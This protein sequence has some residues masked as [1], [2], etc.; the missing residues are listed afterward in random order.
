MPQLF[1]PKAGQESR[2]EFDNT[3][4][5]L[6]RLHVPKSVGSTDATHVDSPAYPDDM[7]KTHE[8][9]SAC[10][11]D[12]LQLPPAEAATR[13]NAHLRWKCQK[14]EDSPCNLMSWSSSLLFLL[15][16]GFHRQTTERGPKPKL[17]EISLI[18]IDT[19]DFPKQT[20]LRDL[21]ALDYYHGYNEDLE[22]VKKRWREKRYYFGEYLTQGHLAI[23]GR[24]VQMTMQ[25]LVDGGLLTVICPALNKPS[26]NWADW[27]IPVCELR[28]GIRESHVVDQKQIRSAIFMARG[29]VGHRFLVPFALM[30][31][32]LRSRQSD[33]AA[34]ANAFHSLFTDEELDFRHVTYDQSSYRM[35][36][37][38]R[39]QQLMEAVGKQHDDDDDDASVTETARLIEGLGLS[40]NETSGKPA[41]TS[42]Y[43]GPFADE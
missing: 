14:L 17:S 43:V 4:T 36:E 19:R 31:L 28:V 35:E 2:F 25:Q 23:I 22:V 29:C 3:P 34:I 37:L 7:N 16:Y 8:R 9:G 20:F 5:Y 12:L 10:G 39:F 26:N 33:N 38:R 15:H 11:Q 27:A 6:F 42:I 1:E 30:L 40:T 24:C 13:L 21:D 18:M 41:G 32:G